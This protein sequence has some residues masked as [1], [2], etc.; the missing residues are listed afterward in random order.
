MTIAE[1]G[2]ITTILSAM[3]YHLDNA[4]L[5]IYGCAV[6]WTLAEY[7]DDNKVM[8]IE[9]GGIA[10]IQSP[11]ET[12]PKISNVEHYVTLAFRSLAYILTTIS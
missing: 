3:K 8:I 7:N 9:A 4:N 2:G 5:Q 1:K 12:H 10:A 6:L 11:K